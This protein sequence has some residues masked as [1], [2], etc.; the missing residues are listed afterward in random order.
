MSTMTSVC[1]SL[2]KW[3]QA[4]KHFL[5]RFC[6]LPLNMGRLI[7]FFTKQ[8]LIWFFFWDF[9]MQIIIKACDAPQN[10]FYFSATFICWSVPPFLLVCDRQKESLW[11]VQ[12]CLSHEV[13]WSLKQ[14]GRTRKVKH[15][16]VDNIAGHFSKTQKYI[17]CIIYKM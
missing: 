2:W 13:V 17:L 6:F 15:T 4:R 16:A 5:P 8:S 7:F 3:P 1:V 9:V 12:I 11:M 10:L 14:R